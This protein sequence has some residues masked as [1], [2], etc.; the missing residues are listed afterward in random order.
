MNPNVILYLQTNLKQKKPYPYTES[1]PNLQKTLRVQCKIQSRAIRL[2]R[3]KIFTQCVRTLFL[4]SITSL[5]QIKAFLI[6]YLHL[7][8]TCM[9]ALPTVVLCIFYLYYMYDI[10]FYNKHAGSKNSTHHYR[11]I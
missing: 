9:C 11:A 5:Y 3:I 4:P 7:A 8:F 6:L 2:G 1:L 10:M